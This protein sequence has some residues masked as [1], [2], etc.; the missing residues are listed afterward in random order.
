V[1]TESTL[2]RGRGGWELLP[3][4]RAAGTIRRAAAM[5][6]PFID[7]LTWDSIGILIPVPM[8][9]A[10][11]DRLRIT[12]RQALE[13]I[14]YALRHGIRWGEL[15]AEIGCGSGAGCLR[16]L[17][18]WRREEAWKRMELALRVYLGDEEID[19]DRI[20][21]GDGRPSPGAGDRLGVTHIS[22]RAAST[23]APHGTSSI[24][25]CENT[26]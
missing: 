5:G 25:H 22:S 14:V 2:S 7:Y 6:V 19:W 12:D 16:R 15:P 1:G 3:V 24:G 8:P 26:P 9:P 23:E 20:Q 4:F 18:E 13:G 11:Y 21:R 17:Q 10:A